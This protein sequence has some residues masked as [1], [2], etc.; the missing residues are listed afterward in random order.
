MSTTSALRHF[1]G[2]KRPSDFWSIDKPGSYGVRV[3]RFQQKNPDGTTTPEL[4]SM[5]F[6]HFGGKGEKPTDCEDET[7]CEK[8]RRVAQLESS[9]TAA[10]REKADK[11]K[12]TPKACFVVVPLKE[13]ERLRLYEAPWAAFRGIVLQAA[14]CGGW[15]GE[16][17]EDK[18]WEDGNVEGAQ[19]EQAVAAGLDKLCGPRGRD[20]VLTAKE[21]GKS[22]RYTVNM[23]PDGCPVLPFPEDATVLNPI[24]IR[25][26]INAGGR[27]D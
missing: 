7:L 21:H 20:I 22:L 17:P 25:A 9:G 18:A 14:L 16:Y 15:R 4:Y 19:F 1:G 5:R 10:D 13:P 11:M 8:C 26:R 27:G 2:S 24:E 6:V 23:I 3:Y 12:R